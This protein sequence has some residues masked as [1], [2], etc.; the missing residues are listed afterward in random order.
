MG[1]IS[2]GAIPVNL[3]ILVKANASLSAIKVVLVIQ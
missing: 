1:N 2:E 3:V